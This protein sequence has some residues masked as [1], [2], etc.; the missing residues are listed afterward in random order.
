MV[1]S[2][3]TSA[4][5]D[6]SV[7]TEGGC[8]TPTITCDAKSGDLFSLGTTNVS[9]KA[10]DS[11]ST[12]QQCQFGIKVEAEAVKEEVKPEPTCGNGEGEAY[13][14]SS[15]V[16][17]NQLWPP[18]HKFSDVGL[19]IT[20]KD[21][22]ATSAENSGPNTV[23]TVWSDE[24]ELTN[25]GSGNFAPDAKNMD[26]NT[27]LRAE[28][29]GTGDGRVY[30][31]IS[32]GTS[33]SGDKAFSCTVVTVPHDMSAKSIAAVNEEAGKAKAYC[34]DN[35]GSTPSSFYQH[36]A[37]PEA[38]NKAKEEMDARAKEA[39]AK[40]LKAAE[41]ALKKAQAKVTAST[42][43]AKSLKDR[44]AKIAAR[45]AEV[46]KSVKEKQAKMADRTSKV[47]ASLKKKQ[48]RVAT[49]ASN[50]AKRL[51]KAQARVARNPSQAAKKALK[52]A[53]TNVDR[54]NKA[55]TSLKER[56][57]RVN[58]WVSK[59]TKALNERQARVDAWT[60]KA[61]KSLKKREAKVATWVS[62]AAAALKAAQARV[63]AL[64]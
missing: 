42:S 17:T 59:V 44:L 30:L 23:T 53:Q 5:V 55:A 26:T 33:A 21:P 45:V 41:G 29:S 28:R 43:K 24:P 60:S 6:F 9:C 25:D 34:E 7:K 11:C 15:I 40:A 58:V 51:E 2:Y 16:S 31:L 22:C 10:V 4:K 56:E 63:T 20:E 52:K 32:K 57:A 3:E 8:G 39:K 48:A 1:G 38:A 13:T 47:L 64:S 12:Q 61:I 37:D 36:G 54:A 46:T 35:N 14:L 18:N 49:W 19:V 27:N 62:R 50:A